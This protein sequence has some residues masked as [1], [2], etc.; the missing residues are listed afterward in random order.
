MQPALGQHSSTLP[1]H[2]MPYCAIPW[3]A[4]G[5][6]QSHPAALSCITRSRCCSSGGRCRSL[7]PPVSF[8]GSQAESRAPYHQRKMCHLCCISFPFPH[9][10]PAR[11]AS[12]I[13]APCADTAVRSSNGPTSPIAAWLASSKSGSLLRYL[14]NKTNISLAKPPTGSSARQ[15]QSARLCSLHPSGQPCVI[16]PVMHRALGLCGQ[17][18][19]CARAE[20]M[21]SISSWACGPCCSQRGGTPSPWHLEGLCLNWELH[22]VHGAAPCARFRAWRMVLLLV[23]GAVS[24]A[25]CCSH[26][27]VLHLVHA[28]VHGAWF[29]SKCRVLCP[30]H[31][32][33][34]GAWFHA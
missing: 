10:F 23:H 21:L 7:R 4:P 13:T 5:S 31:G 15:Q 26:C 29:C 2:A 8:P 16:G 9:L 30:V 3:A 33:A 34:F 1:C 14:A 19:A 11:C 24:G 6:Q 32:V 28:S 22:L 25:W 18:P 27:M 12:E 20:H 17:H